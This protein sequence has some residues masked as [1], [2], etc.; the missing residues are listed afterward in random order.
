MNELP[1][2]P[3]PLQSLLDLF[4]TEFAEVHFAD[5]DATT[6]ARL[7]REV[8]TANVAMLA[9][10]T[11]LDGARTTLQER[12]DTLVQ[13]AHRALAYAKV[14]AENDDA[15][16]ARLESIALP[17]SKGRVT[18]RPRGDASE[19]LVLS[20]DPQHVNAKRPRARVKIEA[21]EP[22]LSADAAE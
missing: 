5:I 1:L 16:S 18:R 4:A 7:A 20:A 21:T 12:R 9:A 6:L 10:Q 2:L 8:E 13:H 19:V 17:G 14:Y 11:V 3:A 15:L 22:L